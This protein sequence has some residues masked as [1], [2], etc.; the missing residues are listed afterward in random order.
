MRKKLLY[1]VEAAEGGVLKHLVYLTTRLDKDKFEI[2][3][4]LSERWGDIQTN[5]LTGEAKVK[6]R[7]IQI[8]AQHKNPEKLT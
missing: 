6:K 1:W 7:D 3:M 4:V 5:I 2:P 8:L